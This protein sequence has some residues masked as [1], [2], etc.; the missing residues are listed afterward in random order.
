MIA[1]KITIILRRIRFSGRMQSGSALLSKKTDRRTWR[2]GAMNWT[3]TAFLPLCNAMRQRN[4][5][6]A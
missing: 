5:Q 4:G 6:K 3:E 1:D 2:T